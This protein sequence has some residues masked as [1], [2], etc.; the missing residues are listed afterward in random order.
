MDWHKQKAG[1]GT[2]LGERESSC[3][4]G[5]GARGRGC[6]PGLAAGGGGSAPGLSARDKEG[7]FVPQLSARSVRCALRL[8]AREGGHSPWL[9]AGAVGAQWLS[10]GD[11][12]DVCHGSVR[13]PGT[14]AVARLRE[15]G[16]SPWLGAGC[17]GQGTCN[18]AQ[19]KG[20]VTRTMTRHL[21]C[22]ARA[23][24]GTEPPGCI[25][26]LSGPCC[27]HCSSSGS[28]GGATW[29]RHSLAPRPSQ[30]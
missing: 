6:A 17:G 14:C 30:G 15:W 13:G 29:Q 18:V 25:W 28:G 12:R 1:G 5:L 9:S 7:L 3:T 21:G 22:V 16:C 10:A 4:P 11:Q 26:H 24:A 8:S 19:C 20:R 27:G 23:R 2:W